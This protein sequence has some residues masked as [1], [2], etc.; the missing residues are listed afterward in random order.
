MEHAWMDAHTCTPQCSTKLNKDRDGASDRPHTASLFLSLSASL[1]HLWSCIPTL[2]VSAV[3]MQ[4]GK[5]GEQKKERKDKGQA[6]TNRGRKEGRIL[7]YLFITVG[8]EF[9]S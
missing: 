9:P 3:K 8:L 5:G 1:K 6:V 7:I 2:F 4:L